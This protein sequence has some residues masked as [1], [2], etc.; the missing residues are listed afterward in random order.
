MVHDH[1]EINNL[2][3]NLQK[4]QLFYVKGYFDTTSEYKIEKSIITLGCLGTSTLVKIKRYQS[5]LKCKKLHISHYI[6][7]HVSKW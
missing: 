2:H 7:T 6:S 4:N 3:T 5:Y 1:C